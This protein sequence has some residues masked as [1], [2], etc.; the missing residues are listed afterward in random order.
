MNNIDVKFGGYHK[1][2]A[3]LTPENYE[4]LPAYMQEK[5]IKKL[6]IKDDIYG[7]N[8]D[9]MPSLKPFDFIDELFVFWTGIDDISEIQCLHSLK[10]LYLDNGDKTKIDFSNFPFL[11]VL[12]SWDR[13]NIETA[14]D[15]PSLKEL[16]L[17]GLKKKHYKEGESLKS[18]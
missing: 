11:E 3:I 4:K 14:W 18:F 2:F 10:K 6:Q 13:K 7:W 5:G 16:K 9:Y 17:Y 8:R 1:E 15:I 12:L